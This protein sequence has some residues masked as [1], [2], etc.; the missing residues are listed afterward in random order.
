MKNKK[1]MVYIKKNNI[2]DTLL[3]AS[4]YICITI[5]MVILSS[6]ILYILLNGIPHI[7]WKFLSDP[8]SEVNESNKG[9]LPMIINTLYIIIITILISTPIGISSAIYLTQ[10]AK[11]GKFVKLIRFT[12]EILSGIPS[13]I[14]GLFGYTVFCVMFNLGTSIIAGS[15]TMSICILPIIIRTTEESLMS[16]PNSYK[17]GAI[18]LGAGKF[19][20]IKN[21]IVPCAMP[22]IITAIILSMGR[23]IGE[24]AA[25][26]YTSGMAYN[27]TDKIISHISQSGRTL[28]LHLY[29]NAKQAASENA[30]NVAFATAAVLLILVFVLNIIA[31]LLSRI[32]KK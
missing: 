26:L 23:I 24:S 7:T 21:I 27:I 14:F 32:L 13:I 15:L 2:S 6:I 3:K 29:Q 20:V 16:V 22:G 9:I 4:I 8:Y 11:Q 12:T 18:A 10:Y 5:T 30:F 28:T 17:E 1:I 25:L 19:K 31:T